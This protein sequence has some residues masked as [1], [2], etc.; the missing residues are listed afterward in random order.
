MHR[1]TLWDVGRAIGCW[2]SIV[3][4]GRTRAELLSKRPKAPNSV[5]YLIS[6]VLVCLSLLGLS[7]VL[8]LV[9][10]ASIAVIECVR[11]IIG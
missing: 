3:L 9:E 7:D 5:L 11:L 1:N 10:L 6:H 2:L 4:L 8:G